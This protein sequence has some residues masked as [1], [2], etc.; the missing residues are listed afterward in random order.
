MSSQKPKSPNKRGEQGSWF[1]VIPLLLVFGRP[2]AQLIQQVFSGRNVSLSAQQIVIIGV[3]ALAI[4]VAIV[5]A[6]RRRTARPDT[7]LPTPAS[8]ERISDRER[9][10]QY[11]PSMPMWTGEMKTG[12]P[13]FSSPTIERSSAARSVSASERPYMPPPPRFEPVITGKLVLTG[14]VLL[15]LMCGGGALLLSAVPTP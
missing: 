15:V 8:S 7:R 6:G 3:I 10:E 4:I 13:P 9:R 12:T 5:R 1:W 11:T 2:L 14:I